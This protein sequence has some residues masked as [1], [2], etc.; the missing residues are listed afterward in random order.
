MTRLRQLIKAT[1][2][3]PSPDWNATAAP[4]AKPDFETI[5]QAID[6]LQ[7]QYQCSWDRASQLY[8]EN[9]TYYRWD[10]PGFRAFWQG[11]GEYLDPLIDAELD[12]EAAAAAN[13]AAEE[14]PEPNWRDYP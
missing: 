14:F 8:F 2:R 6:W 7:K 10:S 12:A 11:L 9:E 3:S 1:L 4:Q 13:A 5:E